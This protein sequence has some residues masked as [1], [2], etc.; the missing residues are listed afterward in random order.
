MPYID[1]L[2]EKGVLTRAQALATI[3]EV[4]VGDDDRFTALHTM[5]L[6][7]VAPRLARYFALLRAVQWGVSSVWSRFCFTGDCSAGCIFD[8]LEGLLRWWSFSGVFPR[9]IR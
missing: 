7:G 8:W 2:R 6:S 9:L 4:A 3:E 5:L 1:V